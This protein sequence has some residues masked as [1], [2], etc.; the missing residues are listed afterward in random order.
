[1]AS[2][3]QGQNDYGQFNLERKKL[4]KPFKICMSP[5]KRPPKLKIPVVNEKIEIHKYP[6]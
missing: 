6:P 4:T 2:G 3:L 1:M 5:L